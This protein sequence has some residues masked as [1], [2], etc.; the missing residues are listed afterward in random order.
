[1][2][3]AIIFGI[4][5]QDGYYL[6]ELLIAQNIAVTG[7]ARTPGNHRSGD[8]ADLT[9]VD[10]LLS[11]LRPDYVFH[12]AAA[13]TTRH[14]V[15]QTNRDT[16]GQGTWNILECV[17]RHCPECRVFL[18]GS[19]VQFA[20]TGRPISED[21]PFAADSPYAVSRIESVYTARYYREKFNLK[22]YV[23]YLFHH[24]SPLRGETHVN[25][26][27]ARFAA[28][29]EQYPPAK[30]EIGDVSVVKEFN[31]AGDIVSAIWLMV[32]QTDY[33]EL[34]IGS[35]QGHSIAEWLDLCFGKTGRNWRDFVCGTPGFVSEY[36][37]L[38]SDPR[39]LF[40]LNWRPRVG[41]AQLCDMMMKGK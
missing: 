27:I 3:Q 1:M 19:A 6:R 28:R 10:R 24:D 4:T 14:E 26:K 20:N 5:G 38:V 16:I 22:V 9:L 23:G 25:Q 35:G 7:V 39:R 37:T 15:W 13:S 32:N 40:S 41:L 29:P 2:K 11:E 12:L 18:A 34:V 21:T 33:Y 36:Q 31:F 30:L 17:R 8:V